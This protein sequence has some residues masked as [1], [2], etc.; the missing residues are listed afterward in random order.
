MTGCTVT[1]SLQGLAALLT[2]ERCADLPMQSSGTHVGLEELSGGAQG[3]I[4]KH[5]RH[6]FS[7]QPELWSNYRPCGRS[8]GFSLDSS[9]CELVTAN[10]AF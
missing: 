3:F 5:V 9:C 7:S 8:Q 6:A 1:C 10:A 2:F 4:P